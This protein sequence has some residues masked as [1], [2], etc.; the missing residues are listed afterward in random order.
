MASFQTQNAPASTTMLDFRGA[1]EKLGG[2]AKQCRFAVRIQPPQAL[3]GAYQGLIKDLV[4][5]CEAAEFPGRGLDPIEVKYYGPSFERP[6][7]PAYVKQT[8]LTF[9]CRSESYERE[10]FDDWMEYINPSSTFDFK[11]STS[12]MSEIQVFQFADYAKEANSN[13]P[14]PVYQWTLLKAWPIVVNPQPITWA[15]TSDILRLSVRFSYKNWY[16]P[17]KDSTGTQ[18]DIVIQP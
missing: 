8:D 3:L 9:I 17:N 13:A 16:R 6:Y 2:P 5:L 18:R 4:F 14:K 12:Y 15:D 1:I 7:A 11:Y 10:F